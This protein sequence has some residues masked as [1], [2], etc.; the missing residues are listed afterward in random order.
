MGTILAPKLI[1][2]DHHQAQ[3]PLDFIAGLLHVPHHERVITTKQ[4]T[5]ND[6]LTRSQW[7]FPITR[8]TTS[9]N[10]INY[11]NNNFA[12]RAPT[13]RFLTGRSYCNNTLPL[14][15]ADLYRPSSPHEL[16]ALVVLLKHN[17]NQNKWTRDNRPLWLLR[18]NPPSPRHHRS[19]QHHRLRRSCRRYRQ[20]H[21][22]SHWAPDV[23]MPSSTTMT[24][25][26]GPPPRNSTTRPSHPSKKSLMGSLITWP[27]SWPA[28][29]T[30]LVVLIGIA[31]SRCPSM[32]VQRETF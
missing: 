31:S 10:H 18:H 11:F 16:N 6:L 23:L 9:F 22:L 13:F 14:R 17:R 29:A 1:S 5:L 12:K 28:C 32:M 19:Y 24:P 25:I 27:C 8:A 20:R 2:Q 7:T 15:K 4:S 21:Q 3:M 26:P 30:G